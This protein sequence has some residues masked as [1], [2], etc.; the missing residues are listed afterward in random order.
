[1]SVWTKFH[2]GPSKGCWD[3]SLTTAKEQVRGSPKV[4]RNNP[5]GNIDI[6][7][8]FQGNLYKVV[9]KLRDYHF[10]RASCW[11]IANFSNCSILEI[12]FNSKIFIHICTKWCKLV[13]SCNLLILPHIWQRNSSL[14]QLFILISIQMF[15]LLYKLLL[16]CFTSHHDLDFHFFPQISTW[17]E[18]PNRIGLRWAPRGLSR[19]STGLSYFTVSID[20]C[21]ANLLFLLYFLCA[22]CMGLNM[23]FTG[24]LGT[25]RRTVNFLP[26][27]SVPLFVLL[28]LHIHSSSCWRLRKPSEK[29]TETK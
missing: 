1:M 14:V 7:T 2:G 16:Y 12:R 28:L 18:S 4:S 26:V 3:I 13:F 21:F 22:V 11:L 15:A 25:C 23:G 8:T 6:F 20:Y 19:P 10:P 24:R 29:D 17:Q 5:L 9:E 27:L